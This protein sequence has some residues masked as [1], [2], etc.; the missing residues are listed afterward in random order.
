[1]QQIVGAVF[2]SAINTGTLKNGTSRGREG[3]FAGFRTFPTTVAFGAAIE[4]HGDDV[5][6]EESRVYETLKILLRSRWR[7]VR[8]WH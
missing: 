5:F 8:G 6:N 7:L 4:A 1:M 2:L 3:T